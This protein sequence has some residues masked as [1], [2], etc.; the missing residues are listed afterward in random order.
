VG[1]TTVAVEKQYIL[2]IYAE[3]DF[4]AL[5]IQ[6]AMRLRHT[7]IVTY[8]VMIFF[9]HYL[10]KGTVFEKIVTENKMCFESSSKFVPDIFH[11]KKN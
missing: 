11:P 10:V 2:H 8:A 5:G 6:H 9:P 4:V 3:C 1:S 7:V